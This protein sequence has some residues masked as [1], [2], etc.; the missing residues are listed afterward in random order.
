MHISSV[1]FSPIDRSLY[2]P[3]IKK[4]PRVQKRIAE[5]LLK[6]TPDTTSAPRQWALD[7][8]K[9]PKAMNADAD[10]HLSSISF[11]T[12]QFAPDADPFSQKARVVPTAE[13]TTI[14]AS[15]A[16]RSVGYKSTT[17]PGLSDIGVPFDSKLGIIPND[18]HG[19]VITP[20]AGPGNL[21]AGHVH[22]LYCA[23]WVKRGPTGVIASTMQDAFSSADIIVQDWENDVP[24]LNHTS[25]DNQSTGLGW[26]GIR[27]EVERK[28]VRPLSWG[29]WKKINAEE[30]ARGKAKGKE[31]EKFGSVGEMLGVLDK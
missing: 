27:K 15:L 2:P 20:A 26:E 30:R 23:G 16:F 4:L 5:V 12:Q 22:G 1:A 28:G 3:D 24:F 13:K 14:K 11:T 8:L 17:L 18:A 31:R 7:F 19:R 6:G 29:D 21:T 9:A 25:G 10:G